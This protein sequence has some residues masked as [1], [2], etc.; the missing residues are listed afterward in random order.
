MMEQGQKNAILAIF[1]NVVLF[2]TKY[3]FAGLSGS[4]ALKGGAFDSMSDVVA[5]STVFVG[6][7]I[8]RRKTTSFPYDLYK[9]ENLVTEGTTVKDALE[10]LE[11][12][13]GIDEIKNQ[14][15]PSLASA[16]E[17]DQ[18]TNCRAV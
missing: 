3:M 12:S 13:Y 15:E 11:I 4:I 18:V 6:L 10:G 8:S 2:A 5:S 16:S 14:L 9:V 7:V 17:N 1:V